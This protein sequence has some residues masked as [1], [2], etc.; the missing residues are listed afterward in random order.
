MKFGEFSAHMVVLHIFEM[1]EKEE[2]KEEMVENQIN[3]LIL[4][5]TMS[6]FRYY[7]PFHSFIHSVRLY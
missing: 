6:S 4:S 5:S 2:E 7:A 3:A 1:Y